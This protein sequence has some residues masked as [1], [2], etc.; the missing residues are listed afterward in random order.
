MKVVLNTSA[1]DN[2]EKIRVHGCLNFQ[3]AT[4]QY[5]RASAMVLS[6]TRVFGLCW[7]AS[8]TDL[9]GRPPCRF[10][11]LKANAVNGDSPKCT[12]N[13]RVRRNQL[14]VRLALRAVERERRDLDVEAFAAAVTMP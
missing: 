14:R 4:E 1:G 8:S 11:I 2:I 6:P 7:F 10:R 13:T 3:R 5:P 9:T 12:A